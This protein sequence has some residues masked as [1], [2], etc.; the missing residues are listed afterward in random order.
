M[1]I[2]DRLITKIYIYKYL[3]KTCKDQW[4]HS[5]IIII[6]KNLHIQKYT[7]CIEYLIQ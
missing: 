5:D 1:E 4:R 2:V 6:M 7:A 3:L